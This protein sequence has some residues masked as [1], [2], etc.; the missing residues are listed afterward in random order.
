ML[1]HLRQDHDPRF[2]VLVAGMGGLNFGDQ[3][4]RTLMLD[5][6]LV[7]QR[8]V[9][10][11]GEEGGIE[12]FL[13]DRRVDLERLAD[14]LGELA[15]ARLA[16]GAL[17][18]LEPALDFAMI[19]LQQRDRVLRCAAAAA[20]RCLRASTLRPFHVTPLV[21]SMIGFGRVECRCGARTPM[22][23]E[24]LCCCRTVSATCAPPGPAG[25]RLRA[26]RLQAFLEDRG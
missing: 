10:G 17:E 12:Y 18:L 23:P 26:A 9:L 14:L 7:V 13:L 16:F 2:V 3:A 15:A 21:R 8:A 6:G 19:G 25:S 22:S 4:L 5:L 20:G 24:L 1:D 11:R